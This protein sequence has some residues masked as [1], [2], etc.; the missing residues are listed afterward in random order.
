MLP[1]KRVHKPVD[2]DGTTGFEQKD[3]K[4]GTLLLTA[5][6]QGRSFAPHLERSEDSKLHPDGLPLRKPDWKGL[7]PAV[8]TR[9]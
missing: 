1:P 2:G 6:R 9:S 4:N 7:W 8:L 3:R 5:Q